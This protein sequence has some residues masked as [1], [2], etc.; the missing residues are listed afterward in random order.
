[1]LPDGVRIYSQGPSSQDP[2]SSPRSYPIVLT[3]TSSV[4]FLYFVLRA[5]KLVL[6]Y[7]S[8]CSTSMIYV[9]GSL[10]VVVRAWCKIGSL[11]F[12]LECHVLEYDYLLRVRIFGDGN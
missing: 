4:L 2:S 10:I 8:P 1:M 11:H 9:E 3:G 12:C 5:Q 6:L 7:L